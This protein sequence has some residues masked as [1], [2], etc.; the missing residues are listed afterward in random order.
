MGRTSTRRRM[1]NDLL[2]YPD[3]AALAGDERL[4]R[5]EGTRALITGGL[6]FI[7]SNLV[8]ALTT[9]G[10]GVTVLDALAPDQGGNRFNLHGIED[11]VDLRI[12]D[13]RDEAAVQDAVHGRD[14]VFHLAASV[15]H[16]D[17]LDA[18]FHD[19]EINARGTLIVLEAVR[20][21][22]PRARVV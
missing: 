18:P 2:N 20:Q 21:R 1:T 10:C 13:I 6:G 16:L 15:S 22:A 5:F 14:Y 17:S 7:G 19:L 12:A 3:R 4:K 9:L 11:Q 8:H